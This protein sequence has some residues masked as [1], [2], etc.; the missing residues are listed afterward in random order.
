MKRAMSLGIDQETAE[1]IAQVSVEMIAPETDDVIVQANGTV[2]K[3]T[4]SE[5]R[6]ATLL[7]RAKKPRTHTGIPAKANF[8]I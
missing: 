1:I 3:V 5:T 7:Q 6:N 8:H 4:M 2:I